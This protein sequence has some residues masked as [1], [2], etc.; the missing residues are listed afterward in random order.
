MPQRSHPKYI[1]KRNKIMCKRMHR[2]ILHSLW[3]LAQAFTA[4]KTGP[5][6]RLAG[7]ED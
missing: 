4:K 1:I 2:G 5:A 6:L 7:F 3:P